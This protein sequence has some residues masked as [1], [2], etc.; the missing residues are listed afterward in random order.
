M[1]TPQT[2]AHRLDY[3]DALRGLAC[4]AVVIFHA[5]GAQ[6]P[7]AA[8][9]AAHAGGPPAHH[10]LTLV[11]SFG[12][13]GVPLFLC[14]SGFCLFLPVLRRH[15]LG[16]V[17][18]DFR[19]FLRRRARRILPPYYAAMALFL[20][21]ESLPRLGLLPEAA[22]STTI[23]GGRS[24]IAHVL[25]LHNLSAR[26]FGG[27]NV[28]FWSLATEWQLYLA[29]PLLLWLVRRGGLR[30]LLLTTLAVLLG[31]GALARLHVGPDPAWQVHGQFYRSALSFSYFFALGMAAAVLVSDPAYARLRRGSLLAGALCLPPAVLLSLRGAWPPLADLFWGQVFLGLIAWCSFVA[32]ARFAGRGPL[33]LLVRL[34]A[35]SYSVYLVHQP[36]LFLWT[37]RFSGGW[38]ILSGI[39]LVIAAGYGFHLVFERPFMPGRPRTERQAEVAAI[40]S[41]AP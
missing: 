16:A 12:V 9:R 33:N 7:A 20:V 2:A 30:L 1:S 24:V 27:I 41:P 32:P 39:A 6:E 4:L 5:C 18:V 25:M 31:W 14:L 23:G 22:L 28:S 26:T 37:F 11:T 21:L 15:S 13:F 17:R 40:A 10:G 35:F 29:F 34:G 36:L 8:L 38:G 19:E 3:V